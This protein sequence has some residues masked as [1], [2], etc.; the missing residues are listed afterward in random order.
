MVR[1]GERIASAD[2]SVLADTDITARSVSHFD[3]LE[4]ADAAA[5]RLAASTTADAAV[6]ESSSGGFDV[7]EIAE[8]APLAASHG[9]LS[10]GSIRRADPRVMGLY[11]GEQ[12]GVSLRGTAD[13][14]TRM[15]GLSALFDRVGFSSSQVANIMRS[16]LSP[17]E[18]LDLLRRMQL[19]RPSLA[20]SVPYQ[21]AAALLRSLAGAPS[22]ISPMGLVTA[23][24]PYRSLVAL[25]LDGYLCRALSG[26]PIER[27]QPLHDRGG[28][29]GSGPY[30]LGQF[31]FSRGGVIYRTDARLQQTGSPIAELALQ[32]DIVSRAL[33]GA[34]RSIFETARGLYALSQDPI[35]SLEGL[36][37]L[38]AAVGLLIRNSPDYWARFSVMPPGDQTEAVAHLATTLYLM[39]GTAQG[40]ASTAETMANRAGQ[41]SVTVPVLTATG[42][43]ALARVAVA[44]ATPVRVL[45]TGP[46]AVAILQ[47]S[48]HALPNPAAVAERQAEAAR[49]YGEA[50]RVPPRSHVGQVAA[51]A[52]AATPAVSLPRTARTA[53]AV[54]SFLAEHGFHFK[55]M[56][57]SHAQWENAATGRV[58]SVPHHGST[59]F[60][61]TLWGN[62]RAQIREA[63]TARG[64]TP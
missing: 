45:G 31:Y 42:E 3:N 51:D 49:Y 4:A 25:R 27:N 32:H 56:T 30:E 10:S 41:L 17:T 62:L 21:T 43:L 46:G 47:M 61:D 40:T 12:Q 19:M 44:A 16:G 1:V 63:T 64:A 28:V 39:F 52:A 14:S 38:P 22:R 35:R 11:A 58:V 5:R 60:G 13:R 36:T 53:R 24:E 33:D 57:G 8:L 48:A 23:L 20:D 55:R 18:A 15:E 9:P 34:Q 26:E 7:V 29:V 6:V 2:T 54:E 50:N 59:L 37:R